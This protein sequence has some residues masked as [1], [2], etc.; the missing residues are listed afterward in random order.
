MVGFAIL[1]YVE[2]NVELRRVAI[3]YLQ[4]L[5]NLQVPGINT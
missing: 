3:F 5:Q 1:A 4:Q 2:Y